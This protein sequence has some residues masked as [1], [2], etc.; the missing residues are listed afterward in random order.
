MSLSGSV[1]T[2]YLNGTSVFSKKPSFSGKTFYFK[3]GDYD[4]TAV[5]GSNTTTPYTIVELQSVSIVH[6]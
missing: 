6:N 5:S 4:Q 2:V 1:A 3:C